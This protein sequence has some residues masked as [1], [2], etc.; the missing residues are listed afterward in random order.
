MKFIDFI[1]QCLLIV[2]A[3]VCV[4]FSFTDPNYMDVLWIV[5][6]LV[7]VWQYMGC[8]LTLDANISIRARKLYL[9][10]ASAYL[11]VI[12]LFKSKIDAEQ[13][14]ANWSYTILLP[15]LFVLW[16]FILTF[17]RTF[18][19]KRNNFLPHLNF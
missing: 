4:I 7:G 12:I 1:I 15:W 13:N 8:L 6:F 9:I 14:V 10:S 18:P 2:A 17:K 19:P 3:I 16:Y 11:F 5:L